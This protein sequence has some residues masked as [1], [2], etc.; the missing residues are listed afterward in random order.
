MPM[1]IAVTKADRREL[2]PSP[3]WAG[4]K[5]ARGSPSSPLP[6]AA[7]VSACFYPWP[8]IA[9]ALRAQPRTCLAPHPGPRL[10][11]QAM[12]AMMAVHKDRSR[13]EA[14]Y[15]DDGPHDGPRGLF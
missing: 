15:G 5:F 14:L 11:I 8:A 10:G 12:V 4:Q 6:R 2:H 13:P 9:A 7:P 1:Y 3:R